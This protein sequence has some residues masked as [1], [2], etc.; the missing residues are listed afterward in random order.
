MND[1]N[2]DPPDYT[3]EDVT[4]WMRSAYYSLCDVETLGGHTLTPDDKIRLDQVLNTLEY[5]LGE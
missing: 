4:K 3:W 2:L 5:M 1:K